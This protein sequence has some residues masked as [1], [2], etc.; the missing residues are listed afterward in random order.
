MSDKHTFDNPYLQKRMAELVE[1]GNASFWNALLT[2]NTI[3]IAVFSSAAIHTPHALQPWLFGLVFL[4]ITSAA[5]LLLNF[6]STRNQHKL[7]GWLALSDQNDFNHQEWEGIKANTDKYHRN[8]LCREKLVLL[9][10]C[11][12]ALAIGA[13]LYFSINVDPTENTGPNKSAIVCE[14]V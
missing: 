3:L 7:I 11:L 12:Q 2:M 5:L 8:L 1:S 6:Q 9:I 4:S 10:F 13:I 14:S